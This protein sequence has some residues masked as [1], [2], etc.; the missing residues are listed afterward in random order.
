VVSGAERLLLHDSW[1]GLRDD[2]FATDNPYSPTHAIPYAA[3]H[4]ASHPA[5]YAAA[6]ATSSHP[7]TFAAT[8]S[9][10][11]PCRAR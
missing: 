7:A 1:P 3:A 10:A 4:A 2:S 9:A 11:S 6:A 8:H 5:A